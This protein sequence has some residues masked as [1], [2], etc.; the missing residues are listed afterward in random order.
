MLAD[1]QTVKQFVKGAVDM[2]SDGYN[3]RIWQDKNKKDAALRDV[4]FR[5]FNKDEAN[6]AADFL[7]VMLFTAGYTNVVKRTSK[8]SSF[9]ERSLGGEYVRVVAAK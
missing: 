5:F 6:Y 8:A 2:K 1:V 9:E 7:R 3:R 4:A